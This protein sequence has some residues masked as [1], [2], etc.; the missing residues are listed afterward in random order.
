[1]DEE[2]Q[3]FDL[4]QGADDPDGDGHSGRLDVTPEPPRTPWQC[5]PRTCSN[6]GNISTDLFVCFYFW[7]IHAGPQ[8]RTSYVNYCPQIPCPSKP[9]LLCSS[10][11]NISGVDIDDSGPCFSFYFVFLLHQCC[12]WELLADWSIF[13]HAFKSHIRY[14][15][16]FHVIN[17][18]FFCIVW[19]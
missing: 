12:S 4:C 19:A 15:F 8:S 17:W 3:G 13:C 9:N 5:T 2:K 10:N 6:D 11:G 1:M 18:A 16:C 7:F 14:A